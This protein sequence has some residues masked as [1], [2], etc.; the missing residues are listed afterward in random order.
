M[1]KLKPILIQFQ[2]QLQWKLSVFTEYGVLF[3]CEKI[4]SNYTLSSNSHTNL[5]RL[6]SKMSSFEIK[7]QAFL[8]AL[9]NCISDLSPQMKTNLHDGLK[10]DWLVATGKGIK[11]TGYQL[12]VQAKMIELKAQNVPQKERMTRAFFMWNSFNEK[13]RQELKD[14]GDQL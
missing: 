10:R 6:T 1:S 3:V 14:L 11:L 5:L 7:F 9:G 8:A 4:E 13:K 12:F 2:L